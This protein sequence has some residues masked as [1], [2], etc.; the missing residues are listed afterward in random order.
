MGAETELKFRVPAAR[1]RTLASGRIPGV[2]G[3]KRTQRDLVSTYFD[4]AGHKLQ[5]QGLTLR[6]RRSGDQHLQTIKGPAAGIN[7]GE[8]ET[9]IAGNTPDLT[10]FEGTP[11]EKLAS[12]K[13]GRKLKPVFTTS[14]SRTTVM[15]ATEDSEIELAID[16]G[17][18]IAGRRQ[19]PIAELELELKRGAP[20][21]LFRLGRI[22]AAH[23]AAELYLSAKSER[24]YALARGNVAGA[25]VASPIVL[26]DEMIARE[27]F[28][29][30]AH[31]CFSHFVRNADAVRGGEAEG[32]H[33]MRVGLRR[34]RAAISLFSDLLPGAET[35]RIKTEC[36][37]LTDE[38]AAA[39]EI[40]VFVARLGSAASRRLA[41]RRGRKAIEREFA[42][43]RARA[44]RQIVRMLASDRFRALLVDLL[45]W[46]E[47]QRDSDKDG[48][49]GNAAARILRQRVK[50]A[51]R[52]GRDLG[53]LSARERHRYRIRIKKLRYAIEFFETLFPGKRMRRSLARLSKRLKRIQDALGTL[54]DMAAHRELA[55]QAA[56]G[57]PQAH[58]RA[59]AFASGVVVGDENRA[60]ARL[61]RAAMDDARK[62]RRPKLD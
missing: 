23:A 33:Q 39:R 53:E 1:L 7:R 29:I 24:G 17:R 51:R 14:V 41:P 61:L 59:R 50:K 49:I 34:L 58:R 54:N 8:W 45:A 56:L 26:D 47:E 9:R 10:K 15:V 48:A 3:G 62:L 60:A 46:I 36:K 16:R 30:I 32:I 42:L 5:R 22:L 28:R 40:D 25:T 38:L 6:V 19:T 18:I 31:A 12:R 27:A 52:Q 37:W 20:R 35:E 4:T 57:A 43:R 13:L 11:L 55:T 44:V 2:R 21:A